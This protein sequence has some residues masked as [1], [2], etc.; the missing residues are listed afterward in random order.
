MPAGVKRAEV[1][2]LAAVALEEVELVRQAVGTAK[3]EIRAQ[4]GIPIGT[5]VV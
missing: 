1:V 5:V 3:P 4:V 2:N